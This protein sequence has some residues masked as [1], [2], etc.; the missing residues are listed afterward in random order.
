M[1]HHHI[2]GHSVPLTWC[3]NLNKDKKED[4]KS[5]LQSEYKSEIPNITFGGKNR[6]L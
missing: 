4:V 1:A 2:R 6:F 5:R 3:G